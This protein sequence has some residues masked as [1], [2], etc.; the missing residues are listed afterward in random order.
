MGNI[1][2]ANFLYK[3]AVEC[4][5]K[6]RKVDAGH[7]K[8]QLELTAYLQLGYNQLEARQ[9]KECIEYYNEAVI[10]A[11]HFGDQKSKINAYLGL[12]N[13][14]SYNCEY[15]SSRKYCLK[16]LIV[17]QQIQDKVLQ[18]EAHTLLGHVYYNSCMFDAAAKSFLK[19]HEI[20]HDLGDRNEEVNIYL[21]LGDTFLQLRKHEEAIEF[22]QKAIDISKELESA[23]IKTRRIMALETLALETLAS[24]YC[25][26][27]DFEGAIEWHEK[28]LNLDETEFSDNYELLQEKIL[29][30]LGLAW[31]NLGDIEKAI[32]C[33]NEAQKFVK[34]ETDASN[35]LN[36]SVSLK[37]IFFI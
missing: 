22:Y 29:T 30:G 36:C 16:A 27:G 37:Y 7:K 12:G 26:D 9:Y 23:A 8:D 4:Y 32:E 19:A 14:F 31:E 13:A 35:Y 21:L 3:E 5:Q 6:V 24:A 11:S 18:K 2:T 28:A 17:A 10:L 20:A 33:I 34:K 15:E 25:K 1:Y